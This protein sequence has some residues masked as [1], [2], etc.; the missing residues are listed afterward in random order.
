MYNKIIAIFL[1]FT[2]TLNAQTVLLRENKNYSIYSKSEAKTIFETKETHIKKIKQTAG[3]N[4]ISFI[5]TTAGVSGKG[6]YS[7]LP[8]NKLTIL[9]IQGDVVHQINENVRVYDWNTDETKLALI[10]GEYYEGGIG[11]MVEKL[12]I[13]DLNTKTSLEI[14]GIPYPISVHWGIKGELYVQSLYGGVIYRYLSDSNSI[15]KTNYKDI[16][17]SPDTNFYLRFPGT[18]NSLK[19]IEI[20]SSETNDKITF[21]LPSNMGEPKKWLF[22]KGSFLL[23]ERKDETI[24]P[25]TVLKHTPKNKNHQEIKLKIIKDRKLNG[26]SYTI[27]DVEKQKVVKTLKTSGEEKGWIEMKNTLWYKHDGKAIAINK[28]GLLDVLK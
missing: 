9:N 11:F 7:I 8:K 26:V 24:D 12:L 13:Y 6:G 14:K 22:L 25:E 5:E 27:Y 1:L 20:Y 16:E 3:M 19:K 18:G 23:F 2:I 21:K 15:E 28:Y 4:Y 17:L 10:T